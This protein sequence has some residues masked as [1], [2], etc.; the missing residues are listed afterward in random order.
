MLILLTF[1][2]S[3]TYSARADSV[4]DAL[5][6]QGEAL[7]QYAR[8]LIQNSKKSA[9]TG[10]TEASLK[11]L[12]EAN[13]DLT[14]AKQAEHDRAI[15]PKNYSSNFTKTSKV[16]AKNARAP[17]SQDSQSRSK[18]RSSRDHASDSAPTR[19]NVVLDGSNIP[20]VYRFRGR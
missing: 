5:Q 13:R 10:A 1:L 14:R 18:S 17:A 11:R 4:Q 8:S 15:Q 3:F 20:K 7:D 12:S 19:E 6:A 2:V 16:F 9:A